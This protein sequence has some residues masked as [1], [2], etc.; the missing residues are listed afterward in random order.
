MSVLAAALSIY[1]WYLLGLTPI[2]QALY[3]CQ[4]RTCR[5]LF[6]LQSVSIWH[7]IEQSTIVFFSSLAIDLGFR[8][9]MKELAGKIEAGIKKQGRTQK[10][11]AGVEEE[12]KS[13]NINWSELNEFSKLQEV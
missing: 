5:Q 6:A 4:V 13:K 3:I 1:P 12:N 7:S 11:N 2:T 10:E 9:Q 8:L